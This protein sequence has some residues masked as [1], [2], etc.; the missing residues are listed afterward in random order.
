MQ[1]VRQE[2]T[3]GLKVQHRLCLTRCPRSVTLP[4]SGYQF[5]TGSRPRVWKG[6]CPWVR[7]CCC[8][9]SHF[10][11]LGAAWIRH[12]S[13]KA[14]RAPCRSRSPPWGQACSPGLHGACCK[15]AGRTRD[16]GRTRTQG[17]GW[18]W[19]RRMW[20]A[21]AAC[22]HERWGGPPR[23]T[24]SHL[25]ML[26]CFLFFLSLPFIFWERESERASE[27]ERKVGWLSRRLCFFPPC[28]GRI[29]GTA[30]QL[31]PSLGEKNRER[32][33]TWGDREKR[34]T[35]KLLYPLP[36]SNFLTRVP[37]HQDSCE[38]EKIISEP[39]RQNQDHPPSQQLVPPSTLLQHS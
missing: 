39:A 29:T 26:V 6:P 15:T 16:P 2:P 21:W 31:R 12:R 37:S 7:C 38:D 19:R 35:L 20:Y 18:G 34:V 22:I 13:H 23:C 24:W 14:S 17:L 4:R 25:F 5:G 8:W 28:S 3:T 30:A 33:T 32:G 11:T 9:D 27:R 36:V 10:R 1:K